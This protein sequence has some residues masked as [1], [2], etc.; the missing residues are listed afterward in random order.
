MKVLFCSSE[1][2]PYAKTGGL[3]DVSAAL[4]AELIRQGVE[5]SVVMPLYQEIKAMGLPLEHLESIPVLTGSGINQADIHRIGNTYFVDSSPLF[6][7]MGLY[8]YA[9]SDYPDNLERFALFSKTCVELLRLMGDV[10]IVHCNDWQT[11]L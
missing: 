6:D 11:A 4:P 9:G 5:C 1:V 3:A 7:R 8:S 10:D 2:A